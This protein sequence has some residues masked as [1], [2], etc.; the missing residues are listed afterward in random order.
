MRWICELGSCHQGKLDPIKQAIDTCALYG[1]S[2]KVQLFGKT[3]E[4]A[5]KNV[6]LDPKLFEKALVYAVE[7]KVDFSASVFSEADLKFLLSC[8][9][10]W[11]K[12]PYSHRFDTKWITKIACANKEPIVSTDVMHESSLLFD[13]TKLYCLPYYPVPFIADFEGLFPRFNGF[14]DHTMGL[15]QTQTAVNFGA[16]IIEKHVRLGSPAEVC[17]DAQFAVK[18]KDFGEFARKNKASG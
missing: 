15:H 12:V 14:S 11:V 10:D 16:K 7:N 17:P 3:S 2:L 8:P 4:A 5:K 13:V 18:I 9:V 1:M 6:W